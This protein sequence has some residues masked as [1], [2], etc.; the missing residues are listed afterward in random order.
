MVYPDNCLNFPKQTTLFLGYSTQVLPARIMGITI[1]LICLAPPLPPHTVFQLILAV[2]CYTTEILLKYFI[3]SFG[4]YWQNLSF[5][6]VSNRTTTILF[7]ICI[8]FNTFRP[9]AI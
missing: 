3:P 1:T 8:L 4:T 9:A 2:S 6:K 5:Q 7:A